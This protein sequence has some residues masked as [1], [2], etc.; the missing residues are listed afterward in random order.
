VI[1]GEQV[2]WEEPWTLTELLRAFT[3]FV[4]EVTKSNKIFL[5]IDGLDEFDGNY[6]QQV[7][8]IEFIHSLL[9]ADVKICVS[10]R[11]WNVFED[12]FNTSPN[13]RLEDLT[14][15]VIQRY[16]SSKLSCNLGFAALQRG[17]LQS[18]SSLIDSVSTKACGVF[19]WV[20]LVVQSLLEGLTDG[21]RLSDLHKRLD[22]LPADLEALF[23]GILN[24]VN[25]ERMSQLFQIVRA[26]PQSLSLLELSFAD[27]DDPEFI[28][29]LPT[30]PLPSSALI[31]R[32][33]LMRRR[34]NA[35]C[36]GLLE[37]QTN[38]H[39]L[40]R[41]IVE[42]L[43]R[44][45]KDFIQK[46]DVWNKL[47][48]STKLS[49][50]PGLCLCVSRIAYLK[51]AYTDERSK[52]PEYSI[53]FNA[54]GMHTA[55]SIWRWALSSVQLLLARRLQMLEIQW[56]FLEEVK[57]TLDPVMARGT[58]AIDQI[59]YGNCPLS[60]ATNITSFLHLAVKLQVEPYVTA[61][62]SDL[63]GPDKILVLSLLLRTAVLDYVCDYQGFQ[64]RDP[65]L[66]IVEA[67]L[68]H[69]ATLDG[70]SMNAIHRPELLKLILRYRTNNSTPPLCDSTIQKS[71][72]GFLRW[73][74]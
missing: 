67:L 74:R 61:H 65:S 28:F 48:N 73:R 35:C 22:S 72:T 6:S 11:P 71:K 15:P 46:S 27:E 17:D 20:T 9:N 60:R 66:D 34:L 70:I 43:H 40:P 47:L 23:W 53:E 1:F 3:L 5:L 55:G 2:V 59:S 56:R 19:L 31:S 30:A 54:G 62:L 8:L 49:F 12:T 13:L 16:V 69:G 36:K 37:P 10:S 57:G 45:V 52:D 21:E 24:S 42:Y 14:Y 41:S 44:T 68:Q 26:S 29:R 25:L 64:I 39:F 7:K 4:R 50:D 18:A 58:V 51:I 38:A 63:K 33:E 32:A